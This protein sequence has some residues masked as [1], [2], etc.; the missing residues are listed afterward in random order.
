MVAEAG[1]DIPIIVVLDDGDRP[2]PEP[3][4][5][6]DEG[7]DD[8]F[9]LDDANHLMAVVRKEL[10]H[11]EARKREKWFET[12]F[13]ESRVRSQALMEHIQEA[14]AYIHEGVHPTPIRPIC[15]CLVTRAENWPIS[16]WFTWCRR[17][18]AT[19]SKMCCAA[20]S[21][22]KAGRTGR[23]V[24]VRSN[25]RRSRSCSMRPTRID[26]EPCT[27]MVRCTTPPRKKPSTTGSSRTDQI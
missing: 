24:W 5:L 7:A 9:M 27:P 13:K 6:I 12:R 1:Q 19:R 4:R 22:G 10:R 14:L 21:A 18:T 11:L 17:D 2:Q 15:D 3:A 8:Y 25:G 23:A 26:D 16:N 20:V